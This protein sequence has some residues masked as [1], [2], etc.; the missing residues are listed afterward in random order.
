MLCSSSVP[1]AHDQG[2]VGILNGGATHIKPSSGTC[3]P[4][5]VRIRRPPRRIRRLKQ[6]HARSPPPITP[7]LGF[8]IR[9]R[10]SSG[11]TPSPPRSHSSTAMRHLKQRLA[12]APPPIAPPSASKSTVVRRPS[13]LLLKRCGQDR[14]LLARNHR[15]CC[16]GA[17][18]SRSVFCPSAS[19]VHQKCKTLPAKRE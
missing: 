17:A 18:K 13:Q 2:R 14:V 1:L 16:S 8:S 7:S 15:W 9:G 5:P 4:S 10:A 6:P 11:A 3:T 12:R 19:S